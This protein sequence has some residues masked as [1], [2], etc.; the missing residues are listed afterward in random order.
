M[1]IYLF[2]IS[3]FVTSS[4]SYALTPG[5]EVGCDE[6]RFN[7]PVED[8]ICE[9]KMFASLSE[10]EL[11]FSGRVSNNF[12]P[13]A[14]KEKSFDLNGDGVEETLIEIHNGRTTR[15]IVLLE[16]KSI[17]RPIAN[18]NGVSLHILPL[19]EMLAKQL[20]IDTSRYR[21]FKYIR[22]TNSHS[23]GANYN[24]FAFNGHRYNSI[25]GW[26]WDGVGLISKEDME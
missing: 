18:F 7:Q 21:G 6:R 17:Y 26:G 10:A 24:I 2:Y 11:F 9:N 22:I 3:L 5:I 14:G 19:P 1:R 20:D 8:A 4:I 16:E 23:S 15:W 25:G 12:N 13:N